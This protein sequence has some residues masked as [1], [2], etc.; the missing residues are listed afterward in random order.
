MSFEAHYDPD[1]WALVFAPTDQ[2]P[3]QGWEE[4]YHVFLV[5]A[6]QDPGR[7]PSLLGRQ[8]AFAPALAYGFRRARLDVGGELLSFMLEADDPQRALSG[9]LLLG[10]SPAELERIDTVELAGG[11]RRRIELEVAVGE[12]R[13]DAVSY[14]KR[15]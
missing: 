8:P 12:R 11:H 3:F 10:L 4:G 1:A 2:A 7:W 14:L 15:D 5:A 9:T 6:L 13:V